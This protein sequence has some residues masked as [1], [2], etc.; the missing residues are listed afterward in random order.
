M[1]AGFW[2]CMSKDSFGSHFVCVQIR[3]IDLFCFLFL[4]LLEGNPFFGVMVKP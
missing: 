1:V 2:F 4:H 3:V